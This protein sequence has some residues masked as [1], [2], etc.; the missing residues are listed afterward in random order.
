LIMRYTVR[1]V[2]GVSDKFITN[3]AIANLR[4]S[5]INPRVFSTI[6]GGSS[7]RKTVAKKIC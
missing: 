4:N 3:D 1:N 2:G 6:Y 7:N 5:S